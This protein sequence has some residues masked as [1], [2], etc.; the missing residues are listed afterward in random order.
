M[1]YYPYRRQ[2]LKGLYLTYQFF[3]TVFI[4]IPVWFVLSIPRSLRPRKSWDFR[5]TFMVRLVRH[6]V[7]LTSKTGP[8]RG[9][10]NHLAIT[11]GVDV[12]GV[13]IEPASN[14]IT[15]D[16]KLWAKVANVAPIRIPAYWL[17]KQGS[18]IDVAAPP[19]PGEKVVL[20][21]H[22]GAY[23]RLSAHPSDPTAAIAR[24]LL[25]HVDSVHRVFSVEYRLS[26]AKPYPEENPFPAALL[27]A[28]AAFRYLI[29]V[30]GFAPSDIIIE[31]DSAGGNLAHAL[32]RYLV[33]YQ[34]DLKPLGPPGS[35]ILLS[36]WVD[37]GES[38]TADPEAS[39]WKH[40][41]SDYIDTM[42]RNPMYPLVAFVGPHG[43]GAAEINPYI[44]PA[45]RNPAMK[46]NF[47]GFPKTFIVAGGAEVLYDQIITLRDK[48]I[49]DMGEGNGSVEGEG[50]VRYYEAEDA[51][52]DYIPMLHEPE[53]TET[54]QAI[55]AWF[56]SEKDAF[57]GFM[58]EHVAYY[59][60]ISAIY[61]DFT[62]NSPR[63]EVMAEDSA[64]STGPKFP[65]FVVLSHPDN[66]RAFRQRTA[67][68][69]DEL[70]KARK[71]ATVLCSFCGSTSKDKGKG[72]MKCGRCQSACYCSKDCQRKDWSFHKK[73]C[74]D[75]ERPG[76]RKLQSNFLSN[77]YLSIYLKFCII[78]EFDLLDPNAP[79]DIPRLACVNLGIEPTDIT[80][81]MKALYMGQLPAKQEEVDAMLQVNSV[82][83]DLDGKIEIMPKVLQLWQD[84]RAR[85]KDIGKDDHVVIVETKVLES[86]STMMTVLHMDEQVLSLARQREPFIQNLPLFGRVVVPMSTDSCLE[87]INKNIRHDIKNQYGL[88]GFK[89]TKK[90]F[91]VI[92]DVGTTPQDVMLP[93]E[94]GRGL[95]QKIGR[96][97]IYKPFV[98]PQD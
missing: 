96:E 22:G 90:D 65:E 3:S 36:P 88:R 9:I 7:V 12:Q 20:A 33:E 83:A 67:P 14:Y 44:S 59:L 70:V 57:L 37:L 74:N 29:D 34:D 60:S 18:T 75:N 95:R 45:S 94:A 80:I 73:T 68:L 41:P 11:P 43:T 66:H 61:H 24:G 28:L 2:P 26:S 19:M 81:F 35:L 10:P 42:S 16:L 76:I 79:T 63:F 82:T 51:C 30:V 49:K 38:H 62:T 77:L 13:W 39:V 53:A 31:G 8:L 15:G 50:K 86:Q 47:K 58:Q 52:H 89:M 78:F 85:L 54:L 32:T 72:L 5:R 87:H 93:T 84:Q 23:I 97:I 1:A 17:H 40:T 69:K 55:A 64:N 71:G 4:R 98:M 56:A 48:M 21:L 91:Q 25:K 92:R 46:I 6:M 27:D